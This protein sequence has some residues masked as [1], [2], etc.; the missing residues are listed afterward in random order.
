VPGRASSSRTVPPSLGPTAA[1]VCAHD[2]QARFPGCR[3][4]HRGGVA[5]RGLEADRDLRV[6]LADLLEQAAHP[7]HGV[8][9][10]YLHIVH[11]AAVIR[12]GRLERAHGPEIQAEPGGGAECEVD[13]RRVLPGF[14]AEHEFRLGR[15]GLGAPDGHHG[16]VSAVGDLAA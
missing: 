3:V 16:G 11:V 1:P 4:Q 12:R 9:A 8:P 5:A 2:Q 13:R 14:E 6:L 7:D 15:G 10:A